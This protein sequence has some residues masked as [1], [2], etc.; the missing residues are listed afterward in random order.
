MSMRTE[1]PVEDEAEAST[2]EAVLLLS[3]WLL[4][5]ILPMKEG[6]KNKCI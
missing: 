3:V 5:T 1:G 2:V 6:A 4:L